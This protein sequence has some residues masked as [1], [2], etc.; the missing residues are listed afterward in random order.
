MAV[1]VVM[2]IIDHGGIEVD[3][4]SVVVLVLVDDGGCGRDR[5]IDADGRCRC[6]HS[7]QCLWPW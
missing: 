2:T 5:V 6:R 1:V 4:G 7:G 3:V